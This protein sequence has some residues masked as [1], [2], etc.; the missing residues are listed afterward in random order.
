MNFIFKAKDSLG[1]TKE[2]EVEAITQEAAVQIIQRKG[3]IPVSVVEKERSSFFIKDLKRIW[4]GAR[5]KELVIFFRQLSTLIDSKVPIVPSLQALEEQT[6]N[7]YL[8][9]VIREMED[10]IKDGMSLSESLSKHPLVFNRL[11]ISMI[12]SGEI[13]G[14]LQKSISYIADNIEKNYQLSSKI[15]S[16]LFYPAFVIGA[17][18]IIGFIVITFVL[19]KLTGVIKEMNVAMPWYTKLLMMIGDFMQAYWWAVLIAILGIIGGLI[20]YIKTEEGKKEWDQIKI[21]LPV[22][23]SFFKAVYIARFADNFAILIDGG[24]PMVNALQEVSSVVGNC[25]FRNIILKCADEAKKGGNISDVF[26]KS[27]EIP[28]IVTR[29]VKIGEETGKLSEIMRRTATFY[30]QEVDAM[31]RNI[32]TMIEPILISILGIGVAIM[33]FAVL[34]PIYDI[35]NKIQ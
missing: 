29:M 28:P 10:D 7:Q 21:K 13:S 11:T 25:V 16:A 23:G 15:K 18:T 6:D 24:I 9:V 32:S 17:A 27:E 2:G 30:E 5:P 14:N 4:E 31:T 22:F 3:L 1:K 33:V 35:A 12:R 20:Y 26:S 8:R 34:L 19:P